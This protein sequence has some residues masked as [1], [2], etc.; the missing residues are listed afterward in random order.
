MGSRAAAARGPGA[1]GLAAWNAPGAD[2]NG[3]PGSRAATDGNGRQPGFV[4][5]P[6]LSR[7]ALARYKEDNVRLY[8][9]F[10]LYTF[11][12]KIYNG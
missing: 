6:V 5:L 8:K 1:A 2:R 7:S 4:L 9:A 11:T 3:P 10:I 12:Y